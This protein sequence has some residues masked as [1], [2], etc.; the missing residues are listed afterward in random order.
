[1]IAQL[2]RSN[3][4][5]HADKALFFAAAMAGISISFICKVL[6]YS[7]QYATIPLV[8]IIVLYAVSV[9]NVKM[10]RL[11]EDRAGDNCYYLGFIFTL[12]SL[13]M[14]FIQFIGGERD[15]DELIGN[16]G[17]AIFTTIA[18]LVAR[19]FISQFREDPLEVEREARAD[20]AEAVGRFKAAL[21]NA[22]TDLEAFR[23]ANQQSVEDA[24][25]AMFERQA[26]FFGEHA[27]R[28]ENATQEAMT[29][30]SEG[31]AMFGTAATG[32]NRNAE[33]L[34][35]QIGDLAAKIAAIEAPSN[36]L[37]REIEPFRRAVA[38]LTTG[39][40][41][42]AD[43]E[44]QQN[45]AIESSAVRI[46]S[47]GDAL[48]QGVDQLAQAM[49]RIPDAAAKMTA[50]LA[51]NGQ[52]IDEYRE[53]LG[54]SLAAE[55]SERDRLAAELR[56]TASAVVRERKEAAREHGDAMLATQRQHAETEDAHAKRQ[57]ILTEHNAALAVQLGETRKLA[58]HFEVGLVGVVDELTRRVGSAASIGDRM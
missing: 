51:A 7:Q 20:L 33:A 52:S 47:A 4:Q 22:V 56:E 25:T 41:K 1:M 27:S 53:K 39:L 23:R 24:A 44:F 40:Q 5:N 13:S 19:I 49:L 55:R 57:A 28:F 42:R 31:S 11:R 46:H 45:A 21:D 37:R 36:L 43:A 26:A 2:G 14:A 50:S 38:S 15:V 29:R 32:F 54:A 30:L 18:G 3:P 12:L 35:T 16:F 48:T 6:N 17:I 10:F 34:V 9:S 8:M 58:E